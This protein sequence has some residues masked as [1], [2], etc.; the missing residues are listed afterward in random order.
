MTDIGLNIKYVYIK[1]VLMLLENFNEE[2]VES[3]VAN[4][5]RYAGEE[6]YERYC[7]GAVD[8]LYEFGQLYK[9]VLNY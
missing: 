2:Y 8:I 3:L 4:V 1:N 6:E 7:Y 9:S 5:R